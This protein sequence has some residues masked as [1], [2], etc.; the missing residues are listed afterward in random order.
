M[1]RTIP[2]YVI[3]VANVHV[4]AEDPP[5]THGTFSVRCKWCDRLHR[6]S[7]NPFTDGIPAVRP[8]ECIQSCGGVFLITFPVGTLI[9]SRVLPPEWDGKITK[10]PYARRTK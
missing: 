7:W 8:A 9:H 3:G 1:A 10:P 5:D 2:E 4:T 6:Y